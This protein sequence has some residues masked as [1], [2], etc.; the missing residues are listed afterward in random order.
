VRDAGS[1]GMQRRRGERGNEAGSER[2]H[3]EERDGD[4]FK[5]AGGTLYVLTPHPTSHLHG[6]PTPWSGGE[7]WIA[8]GKRMR[9][10]AERLGA[11]PV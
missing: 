5:W 6:Q 4:G 1:V 11:Q 2:I 10:S 3:P 8:L 9:G 7:W